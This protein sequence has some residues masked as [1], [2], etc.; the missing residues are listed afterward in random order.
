VGGVPPG[1]ALRHRHRHSRRHRH[2][3]HDQ[4]LVAVGVCGNEGHA[5]ECLGSLAL[6]GLS[7]GLV[8]KQAVQSA[9]KVPLCLLLPLPLVLLVPGGSVARGKTEDGGVPGEGGIGRFLKTLFVD[10]CECVRGNVQSG[11]R[12]K[13]GRRARGHSA[14]QFED[15]QRGNSSTSHRALTQRGERCVCN[16]EHSHDTTRHS[17]TRSN[18]RHHRTF[19]ASW[20]ACTSRVLRGPGSASEDACRPLPCRPCRCRCRCRCRDVDRECRRWAPSSP[21]SE[22]LRCRWDLECRR[23]LGWEPWVP[24][25]VAPALPAPA[26]APACSLAR[27]GEEGPAV[28]AV[29]RAVRSGACPCCCWWAEARRWA[30]AVADACRGLLEARGDV[31][32]AWGADCRPLPAPRPVGVPV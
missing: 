18:I 22:A 29:V 16:T 12:E 19:I 14:R 15:T 32:R 2:R 10:E 26:A 6:Q 9:T 21:R 3:Q 24:S 31:C 13:S 5:V 20:I 11:C 27:T 17:M 4:L 28:A 23:R 30:G 25:S 1:P 8:P 7:S